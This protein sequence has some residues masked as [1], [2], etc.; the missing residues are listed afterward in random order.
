[1]RELLA[2]ALSMRS[3]ERDSVLLVN[4]Y[5]SYRQHSHLMAK[6]NRKAEGRTRGRFLGYLNFPILRCITV[7]KAL[8]LHEMG[9]FLERI[10]VQELEMD[11]RDGL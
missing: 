1:M 7:Y 5:I 10:Y 3:D 2:T 9:N 11:W 6:K 8:V 4:P